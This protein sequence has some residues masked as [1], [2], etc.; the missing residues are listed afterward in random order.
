MKN[1][2]FPQHFKD[3][4][5]YF[6]KGL[7]EKMLEAGERG[8][9]RAASDVLLHAILDTAAGAGVSA[10][11]LMEN[12]FLPI[13]SAAA[14]TLVQLTGDGTP[15]Y[16]IEPGLLEA[17]AH[18]D[19]GDM[20]LADLRTP[21]RL[22]YL[23]WGPQPDLL[24]HGKHPVEGVIVASFA[25]DWRLMLTARTGE[26]WMKTEA[27]DH[28][29]LRFP[30]AVLDLPFE[31]AVEQAIAADKED[32]RSAYSTYVD[33]MAGSSLKLGPDLVDK[34]ERE[35]DLN[36]PVLAKALALA[37]NCMAYLAAYPGD[38]RFDWEPDTPKSMLLKLK[39]G[40]KEAARTESK[41]RSLGFL[42]V[43]R[44]GLEFQTAVEAAAV[45]RESL[46][47]TH[48]APDP[49]WRRG[50]WRHQAHGPQFSQRKLI[51]MRPTRVLGGPSLAVAEGE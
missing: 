14:S 35:H 23:H 47:G 51:W 33:S 18:S 37:G 31:E 50:H 17:L 20:R 38:E 32:F 26:G 25:R 12:N 5:P 39:R 42:Q 44:V 24:L 49:H 29:V 1:L 48:A 40:G 6:T 19:V 16:D 34:L 46:G 15:L 43:H 22:Y 11:S 30:E 7:V 13:E 2:Y 27:R 4:R 45:R 3:S 28:F 36:A 9:H 21:N 10:Q 41:I 8:G